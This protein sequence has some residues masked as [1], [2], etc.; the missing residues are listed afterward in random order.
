MCTDHQWINSAIRKIEAD[1]QR[2]ADTHLIKLDLPC[3]QGID[4]YLKDESTHPTGSLKHRLARSLFLYV[5]CNGWI[6]PETPII[7]SS[8]GSTAVSE[9]YFARLLGLPF[10]AV[11]PKCTAIKKIEQIEFYGGKAH[12][13][14]RSDQIYAES[15]RLAAELNGHYMD[16]F[17]YAER[18]TDWRGNSNIAD[19]IYSQMKMED[20]PVPAWIVMSPGTGGTSATIGRFI[21]YQQYDTKLCVVD[22]Q[23]SVFFDFYKTRNPDIKLDCGS[24]IEGIGRPRVEPSFIPNVV[25]EMLQIPDAASVATVHWLEGILGRK[26]GASTGTNLYGALQLAC[27]MKRKGETGSIVTLLCDSGERYLDTYYNADWVAKNIGDLSPYLAKL[28]VFSRT[29]ELE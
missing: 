24:K 27:E 26:A 23:N 25:D 11:M 13:V 14:D 16:Q 19:S 21:R 28:E 1:Y 17:T 3:L 7:E 9:A 10:I 18:A 5:I 29:G 12:L 20:H 15:R 4:I 8:S 6:G 22:P 2:S